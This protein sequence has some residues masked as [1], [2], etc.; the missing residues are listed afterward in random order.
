MN[1]IPPK[2]WTPGDPVWLE[3]PNYVAR[4][5]RPDDVTDRFVSWF[6]DAENMRYV[7][8]PAGEGRAQIVKYIGEFDNRT[9]FFMGL[10]V[11]GTGQLFGWRQIIY[12]GEHRTALLTL[13]I[14]EKEFQG[15]RV[16]RELQPVFYEFLFVT[17]GVHKMFAEIFDGNIRSHRLAIAA[18]YELE[19]VL[20]DHYVA[21]D[22]KSR[23][24]SMY[25]MFE[26][27]WRAKRQFLWLP[28]WHAGL[29]G[30]STD[31]VHR[32]AVAQP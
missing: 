1:S 14:G 32:F 31:D 6:S 19:G 20:R 23:D 24:I 27:G 15:R 17:L 22:G 21:D 12:D 9:S 18:G 5:L 3:S 11:K 8:V 10:F 4:S 2:A 28:V 29:A 26:A 13:V 30:R 7:H 25:G 16:N